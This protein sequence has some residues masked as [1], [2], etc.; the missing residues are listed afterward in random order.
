MD[1]KKRNRTEWEDARNWSDNLL[2]LYFSKRDSRVIVPKRR[3]MFGWT[4]NLAHP[5]AAWWLAG[6]MAIPMAISILERLGLGGRRDRKKAAD[7]W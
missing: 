7:H 2:G 1:Q 6:I 3:P 5:H 4:I